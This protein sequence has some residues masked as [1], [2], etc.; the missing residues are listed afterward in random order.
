MGALLRARSPAATGSQRRAMAPRGEGSWALCPSGGG[1]SRLE[2]QKAEAGWPRSGLV[3]PRVCE[4]GR[5]P[6]RGLRVAG[7]G[8]TLDAS[9]GRA[10]P[11]SAPGPV[12]Y[13]RHIEIAI[14]QCRSSGI[15]CKI[16]GLVLLGRVRAEEEDWAAAPFLASDSEEEEDEKGGAGR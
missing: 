16:H 14:K 11:V 8:R 4:A 9:A 10:W 15:D 3:A 2:P 12:Q 5:V 6:G 1:Q 13:H 7:T